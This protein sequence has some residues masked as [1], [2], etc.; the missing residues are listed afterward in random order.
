MIISEEL[1]DAMTDTL[2]KVRLE[3]MRKENI[4]L[5]ELTE[6]VTLLE[7][8]CSFIALKRSLNRRIDHAI[9]GYNQPLVNQLIDIK[10]KAELQ[11]SDKER[12]L[13]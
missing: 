7:N 13:I 6:D 10:K 2:G 12:E 1:F 9:A 8:V 3:L 5:Q 11:L 4:H